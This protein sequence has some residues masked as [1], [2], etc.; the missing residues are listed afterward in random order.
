MAQYHHGAQNTYKVLPVTLLLYTVS[1][2][3]EITSCL[4][5]LILYIEK[6]F[7]LPVIKF[8]DAVKVDSGI[9]EGLLVL[10]FTGVD[11]RHEKFVFAG[12]GKSHVFAC[13][14]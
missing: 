7:S 8:D 9:S 2:L 1:R 4:L 5:D 14:G 10:A 3:S 12:R 13:V 6:E 11:D